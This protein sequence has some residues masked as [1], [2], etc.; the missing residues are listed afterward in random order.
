MLTQNIRKVG[1]AFLLV[2]LVILTLPAYLTS[3][4]ASEVPPSHASIPDAGATIESTTAPDTKKATYPPAPKLTTADYPRITGV[5]SR[6]TVWLVAQLH[7]WFGAFVLAVPMFVFIIEA[8][9]MATRDERYD[10]MAFEFMKVSII[11]YSLTALLG[12][13]LTFALV[14]L[15][16]DLFK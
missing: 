3:A 5:N 11:A 10:S 2:A 4:S 14:L 13:L 9:G 15:Y 6:V 12:G 7:L 8:I 16:P 1:R